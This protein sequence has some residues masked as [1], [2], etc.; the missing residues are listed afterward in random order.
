[1][2]K[3][4]QYSRLNALKED[5]LNIGI[6][7]YSI[8]LALMNFIRIFDNSFWGDEGYSIM[9]AKMS[10]S[11]MIEA[12]AGDVHPPLY[13]LFVQLLYHLFGDNGP[14]YHLSGWLP[15]LMIVILGCTVVKRYFGKTAAVV[16]ITMSSLMDTAVIYNIEARMYSLAALFVLIAYIAFF[17]M[18]RRNH[19]QDWIVFLAA[20]LGAAY[21]H[22]Y[23][24][25]SVGFLYLL[26]L[27]PAI[28]RK[29]YRYRCVILYAA[30]VLAYLPW[31]KVLLVTY[32]R[33]VES[34][35]LDDI[36]SIRRCVGF[37]LDNE[38]ILAFTA[39]SVLLFLLYRT[40][41]LSLEIIDKGKSRGLRHIKDRMEFSMNFSAFHLNAEGYWVIAGLV[42]VAGTALVGLALSYA[43]RPFFVLRYLFPLSAALY[44]M[45][46]Y[47]ISQLKF[48]RVWAIVFV[49]LILGTHI[50]TYISTFTAEHAFDEGTQSF[51][52][53]VRPEK[54]AIIETNNRHLAWSLLA[55]YYPENACEENADAIWNLD[56]R[57]DH[58][59][60]FWMQ[61]LRE[62]ELKA[63][64]AQNY[65]VMKVYEGDF[66]N[67][68]YYYAY[69]LTRE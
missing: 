14:T 47:C 29:P 30:T 17:Q 28:K 43:V 49:L 8:V 55:Y 57:Y 12:T 56:Q 46:G 40:K 41:V 34:W 61:E 25:V 9:L 21:T 10:V 18:L 68:F 7:A 26:L 66:A 65:S 31:L 5:K 19:T 62:S 4:L 16:L 60:L 15:Y 64:E 58:I 50:P 11:D 32:E 54:D 67:E 69:K 22:Y 13:Y 3:N 24:L 2:V 23:A 63:M 52:A 6:Y 37:L 36:P 35:W 59:W 51:L 1:M 38:I 20:S 27:P 45:I 33:T 44:L 39:A 53:N 42:A 48:S